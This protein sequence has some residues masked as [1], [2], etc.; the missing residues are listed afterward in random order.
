MGIKTG[1]YLVTTR[2][3]ISEHADILADYLRALNESIDYISA[4]VEAVSKRAEAKFGI[5]AEDFVSTWNSYNFELGFTAEGAEHLEE[6]ND[7]AFEHG[8]FD[9]AYDIREY[10]DTS[11]VE[12]AVPAKVTIKK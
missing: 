4:N 9:T 7:W 12:S 3:Y 2:E 8:R 10:I 11:A 6:V 5:L 1:I